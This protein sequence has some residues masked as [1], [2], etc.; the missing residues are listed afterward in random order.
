M[1]QMEKQKA[2]V[3]TFSEEMLMDECELLDEYDNRLSANDNSYYDRKNEK[4][5][6]ELVEMA[7][8]G[9]TAKRMRDGEFGG[10]I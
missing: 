6:H 8:D 2:A 9:V 1:K 4:S 3:S 10:Y 5:S 7:S